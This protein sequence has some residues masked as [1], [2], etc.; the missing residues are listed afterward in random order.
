[1][2]KFTEASVASANLKMKAG[3]VVFKVASWQ[4][5]LGDLENVYFLSASCLTF[6]DLP[7]GSN[8]RCRKIIM[9]EDTHL[10]I[11]LYIIYYY[12]EGKL[13]AI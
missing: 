11:I 1:M 8:Q 2:F 13:E 10:S 6:R 3:S 5:I 9:N 12:V 7:L 4:P